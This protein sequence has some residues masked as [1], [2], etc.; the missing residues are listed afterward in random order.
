VSAGTIVL[1]AVLALTSLGAVLIGVYRLGLSPEGLRHAA[2][3]VVD[4]IGL[5]LVFLAVNLGI[6]G[7]AVLALRVVTDSFVSLYT[8]NDDTIL[9][10]SLLQGMIVQWWRESVR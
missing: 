4:C 1:G 8:L 5:G 10:V 3:R 9:V 6:G 2:A 7:L